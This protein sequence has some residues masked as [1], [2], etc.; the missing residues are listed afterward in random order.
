MNNKE[1]LEQI[2]SGEMPIEDGLKYLKDFNYKE[3]DF[4]KIDFQRKEQIGRAS[5]RERV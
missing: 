4:A 5:C 1:F 3:M 2:K